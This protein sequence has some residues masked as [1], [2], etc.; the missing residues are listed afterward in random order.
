MEKRPD[1]RAS[2]ADR[3]RALRELRRHAAVGRLTVDEFAERTD[4]AL[5]ARTLGDLDRLFRDLPTRPHVPARS[6]RRR[7][8]REL[9]AYVVTNAIFV[10][11]WLET[12]EPDG[13]GADGRTGV[14][15]PAIPI[16]GWGVSLGA[17]ALHDAADRGREFVA[18][19]FR[20]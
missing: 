11:A 16:V 10:A 12:T 8:R 4:D 7:L 14:F 17:R 13:Y 18:A 15:W 20:R 9:R 6:R 1:L 3:D 19:S 5:A 2:D